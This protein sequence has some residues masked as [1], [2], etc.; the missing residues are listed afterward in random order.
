M[1]IK[2]HTHRSTKQQIDFAKTPLAGIKFRLPSGESN[3]SCIR[4][5]NTAAQMRNILGLFINCS[6]I[7]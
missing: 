7:V 1:Y 2:T 6:A 4:E 3:A 5:L